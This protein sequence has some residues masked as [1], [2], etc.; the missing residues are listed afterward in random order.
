[1]DFNINIKPVPPSLSTF[2]SL[3]GG[4]GALPV[5]EDITLRG[6]MVTLYTSLPSDVPALFSLFPKF[7]SLSLSLWSFRAPSSAVYLLYKVGAGKGAD[8][9]KAT[10]ESFPCLFYSRQG[11]DKGIWEYSLSTLLLVNFKGL[12]CVW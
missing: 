2:P 4:I 12:E 7:L 10:R 9:E 1:M 8:V 3:F 6:N 5:I 11:L